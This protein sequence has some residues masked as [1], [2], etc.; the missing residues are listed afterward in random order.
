MRNSINPIYHSITQKYQ[1]GKAN[2]VKFM[3]CQEACWHGVY[4]KFDIT[5]NHYHVVRRHIAYLL[6]KLE[7]CTDDSIALRIAAHP[8][9]MPNSLY[10][11][12]ESWR[13]FE[14]GTR[15]VDEFRTHCLITYKRAKTVS[16]EGVIFTERCGWCLL[17][18]K[19]KLWRCPGCHVQRYCSKTC[20][21]R[22]WQRH[23]QDCEPCLHL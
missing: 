8:C 11:F 22:H 6:R 1:A 13:E 14:K 18:G 12:F 19:E 4:E 5:K 20:L 2:P 23:R 17:E 16:M 7:K 10:S 9:L 15:M 3:L 21:R